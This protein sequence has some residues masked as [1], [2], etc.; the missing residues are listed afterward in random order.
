MKRITNECTLII[1]VKRRVRGKRS[2]ASVKFAQNRNERGPFRKVISNVENI[3][4]TRLLQ[5]HLKTSTIQKFENDAA[6]ARLYKL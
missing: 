5:I 1:N 2:T 4:L 3:S 6:V